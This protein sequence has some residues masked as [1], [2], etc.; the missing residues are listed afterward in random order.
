MANRLWRRRCGRIG[1]VPHEQRLGVRMGRKL[2]VRRALLQPGVGRRRFQRGSRLARTASDRARD[3][4]WPAIAKWTPLFFDQHYGNALV[5]PSMSLPD[6]RTP[7][8]LPDADHRVEMSL[9]QFTA[10]LGRTG[11]CYL[12]ESEISHFNNLTADFSFAD[13]VD[14]PDSHVR[15]WM[16]TRTRSGLHF[17]GMDNFLVQV[18]GE[19][20]AILLPPEA[21]R[22]LYPYGDNVTKSPVDPA[23]PDLAR[24]P[25]FAKTQL[26]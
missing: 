7:Y 3:C 2:A 14:S 17:D 21:S 12:D 15:F 11:S 22:L 9:Q 1:V 24:F 26:Y 25:D 13:F 20:Q 19:K 10:A 8:D 18:Y 16:G 23:I 6:I 4:H 5:R